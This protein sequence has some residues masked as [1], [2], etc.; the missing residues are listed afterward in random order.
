MADKQ[1]L[2]VS[3]DLLGLF[4]ELDE[5]D[6]RIVKKVVSVMRNQLETTREQEVEVIDVDA[7]STKF[8]DVTETP[9][10]HHYI[11]Q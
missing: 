8:D 2:A 6:G 11:E 4:V 9:K 5:L 3:R 10:F 7:P 1:M